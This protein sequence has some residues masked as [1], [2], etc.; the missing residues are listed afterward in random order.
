MQFDVDHDLGIFDAGHHELTNAAA[1]L[2][3][4]YKPCGAGGG[5]IGV[6][7]ATDKAAVAKFTNIAGESGF[8]LLDVSLEISGAKLENRASQ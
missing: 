6:V 4:V 2:E 8:R 1:K 7:F 3:L 5:D